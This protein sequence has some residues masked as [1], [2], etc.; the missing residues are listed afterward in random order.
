M[1][2]ELIENGF[3]VTADDGRLRLTPDGETVI[4]RWTRET[5]GVAPRRPVRGRRARSTQPSVEKLIKGNPSFEKLVKGN[6]SFE[7]FIKG[8]TSVEKLT[9]IKKL[10]DEVGGMST[11]K[12]LIEVVCK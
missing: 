12:R 3:L 4:R 5:K 9:Q 1:A 10:A 2:G 7:K 6:P 11:L 8:N